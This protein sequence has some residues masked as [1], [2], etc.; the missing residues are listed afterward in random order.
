MVKLMGL[1]D[2]GLPLFF[3]ILLLLRMVFKKEACVVS[4]ILFQSTQLK[5]W[6]ESANRCW[7]LAR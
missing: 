2:K 5:Y 3:G 4:G 6:Q 1:V 7:H